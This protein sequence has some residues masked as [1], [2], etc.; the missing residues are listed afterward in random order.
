[1]KDVRLGEERR[2]GERLF[3]DFDLGLYSKKTF[4]MYRGT[5]QLVTLR[6]L[7]RYAGAMIDRFGMDTT[8]FPVDG[9][10]F[11]LHARVRV[12]PTFFAWVMIFEGGVEIVSPDGVRAELAA[13]ARRILA[14]YGE[15]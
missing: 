3:E 12:G 14:Q 15:G 6:C 10:H 9:E 1:M 8:F 7:N 13:H 11:E 2:N 4:G 5:E